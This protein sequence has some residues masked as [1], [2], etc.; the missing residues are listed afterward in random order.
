MFIYAGEDLPSEDLRE[1]YSEAERNVYHSLVNESDD[2]GLYEFWFGLPEEKQNALYNSFPDGQKVAMKKASD[3][4]LKHAVNSVNELV[5]A[6]DSA[7]KELHD[8]QIAECISD[9]S[10]HK[11]I[12][13]MFF[14]RLL[15]ESQEY[16]KLMLKAA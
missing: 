15:P 14:N 16:I 8:D 11:R 6:T 3:S 12:K 4:L 1:V 10:D 5:E 13:A 2:F 9:V 7:V